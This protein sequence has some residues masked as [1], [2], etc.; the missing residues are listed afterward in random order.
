MGSSRLI[1][2]TK[3]NS[4]MGERRVEDAPRDITDQVLVLPD[5]SRGEPF[6]A[7]LPQLGVP[8]RVGLEHRL[9]DL[10]LLVVELLERDGPDLRR[11]RLPVHVD[12]GQVVVAGDRPEPLV[13]RALRMPDDRRIAAEVVEPFERDPIDVVV[14][15]RE[16]DLVE[17]VPMLTAAR[18]RAGR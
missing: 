4:P 11:V 1:S 9:T 8:R 2:V 18:P 14:R 13:G 6:R 17:R 7:D 10:E 5:A 3:S 15:V 12:G 16:V